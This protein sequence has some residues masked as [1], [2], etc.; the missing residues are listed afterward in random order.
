MFGLRLAPCDQTKDRLP[1]S[2]A[3]DGDASSRRLVARKEPRLLETERVGFFRV[4]EGMLVVPR[5]APSLLLESSMQALVC[6]A[7]WA[8]GDRNDPTIDALGPVEV[9]GPPARAELT[10]STARRGWRRHFGG[11]PVAGSWSRARA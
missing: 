1:C 9:V 6:P 8:L 7:H 4:D 2:L 11:I 10:A 3:R 5:A